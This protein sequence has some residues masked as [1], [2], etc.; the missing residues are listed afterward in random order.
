MFSRSCRGRMPGR[1]RAGSWIDE[2]EGTDVLYVRFVF[3]KSVGTILE[4]EAN[5]GD[6]HS[7][8]EQFDGFISK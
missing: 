5:P 3:R 7:S 4:C 1:R 8:V 2:Q 6:P